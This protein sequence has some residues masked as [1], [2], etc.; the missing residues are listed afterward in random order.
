MKI[1]ELFKKRRNNYRILPNET[2][3]FT[4]LV[5]NES[6]YAD[7]V[8]SVNA[9]TDA[10]F[11]NNAYCSVCY[12]ASDENP[13]TML[14]ELVTDSLR[15]ADTFSFFEIMSRSS[16]VDVLPRTD[17]FIGVFLTFDDVYSPLSRY[18]A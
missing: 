4:S 7:V 13:C 16:H 5:R 6:R 17:G 18:S 1:R 3:H 2:A 8:R 14:V 15:V 10:L 9:L 11:E 12:R